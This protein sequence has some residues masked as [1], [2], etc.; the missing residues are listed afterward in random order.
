MYQN[1]GHR[2][3]FNIVLRCYFA[4]FTFQ[5]LQVTG[6]NANKVSKNAL[7]VINLVFKFSSYCKC[8]YINS[9][10]NNSK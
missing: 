6:F 2:K 3:Y 8:F 4:R 1:F 5:K 9:N 7:V 10:S